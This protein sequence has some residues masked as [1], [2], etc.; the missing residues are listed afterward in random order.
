[1][2]I[3]STTITVGEIR[4][5]WSKYRGQRSGVKLHVA[6]YANQ[7]M[8]A[9]IEETITLKHD[10]TVCEKLLDSTCILVEDRAYV[11]HDRFDK[12]KQQNQLFVIRI[13]DNIHIVHPKSL[14]RTGIKNSSIIKDITCKLGNT[15]KRTENR[16]RVVEF[17]DFKGKNIRVCTDMLNLLAEKIAA[18]YKERWKIETFF[19]FIKQ[20]LN[21]KRLFGTS[22]NSVYNQLFCELIAYILLHFFMKKYLKNVNMLSYLLFNLLENYVVLFFQKKHT[23][24]FTI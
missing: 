14:Q 2:A 9:Q 22:Q 21:V 16:F 17:K 23:F 3:D 19:R 4:L 1:M 7:M 24:L 15:N 12:F 18:I 6:F 13:K 11:K 5:K 10:G 8:P 20:N